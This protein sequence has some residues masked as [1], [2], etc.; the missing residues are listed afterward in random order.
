MAIA[1]YRCEICK[2]ESTQ[3]FN[4]GC[5]NIPICQTCNQEMYRVF[6]NIEIGTVVD[7]TLIYAADTMLHGNL[8]TGKQKKVY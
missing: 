4:P 7:D 2:S 5:V 6:K 3:F 1:L 8:P